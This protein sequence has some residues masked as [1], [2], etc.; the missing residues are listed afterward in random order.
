MA[1][2]PRVPATPEP[3]AREMVTSGEI[4]EREGMSALAE[5]I[6]RRAH[7][8]PGSE[9][10]ARLFERIGVANPYDADAKERDI[11]LGPVSLQIDQ[12]RAPAPHAMPKA[13]PSA[14]K[15]PNLP[16]ALKAAAASAEP[17]EDGPKGPARRIG[18]VTS[19][20]V[21]PPKGEIRN[22]KARPMRQAPK[23]ATNNPFGAKAVG[24]G[25]GA[26]VPPLPVRPELADSA[27]GPPRG[28]TSGGGGAG[29]DASQGRSMSMTSAGRLRVGKA[30]E[31]SNAPIVREARAEEVTE[32][33]G[34]LPSGA[35]LPPPV[36]RALE[37]EP[38]PKAAAPKPAP[39]LSRRPPGP[40]AGLDDLFGFSQNEGRMRI[41]RPKK[42]TDEKPS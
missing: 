17:R 3:T 16:P 24:P 35:A 18:D 42:K 32:E 12:K 11:A 14:N 6:N 19:G 34:Y 23:P 30:V 21:P 4:S 2:K 9:R 36:E 25:P 38:A 5:R 13:P 29:D 28:P 8:A 33:I 10:R 40:D 41:S 26:K 37:E 22:G 20:S 7:G 15:Q 39:E 1:D 27:K 31:T